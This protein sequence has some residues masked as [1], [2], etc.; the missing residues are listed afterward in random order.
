MSAHGKPSL[1]RVGW[2]FRHISLSTAQQHHKSADM[3][4]QHASVLQPCQA[5]WPS[6][7]M[8][9][10]A[11]M[12]S[13][14]FTSSLGFWHCWG[15]LL[16]CLPWPPCPS[17]QP[18]LLLPSASCAASTCNRGTRQPSVAPT[19]S[20]PNVHAVSVHAD[21]GNPGSSH[22]TPSCLATSHQGCTAA[23]CWR[24]HLLLPVVC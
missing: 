7:S 1:E 11:T 16:P 24:M 12:V 19:R 9:K 20:R 10:S 23:A 5:L 22:G 21:A 3:H 8:P 6:C 18:W 13:W 15:L 17:Q 2:C 14:P 4:D